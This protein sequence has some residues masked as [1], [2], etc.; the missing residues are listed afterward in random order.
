[1]LGINFT[2]IYGQTECSPVLTNTHP[3]DNAADK[4]LTVGTPIAAYRGPH[5]RSGLS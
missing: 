4:G 2:I 1:M 3:T 5:C